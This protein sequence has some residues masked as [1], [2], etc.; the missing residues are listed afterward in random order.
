MDP[1]RTRI[2][3]LSDLNSAH[4]LKPFSDA[5][6]Q[7]LIDYA[8]Q[9]QLLLTPA[10]QECYLT[11]EGGD[12]T[13]IAVTAPAFLRICARTDLW[14]PGR[15]SF[16]VLDE[17]AGLIAIASCFV[18]DS[19]S[20]PW[21]EVSDHA[22]YRDFVERDLDSDPVKPSTPPDSLWNICPTRLLQEAAEVQAAFKALGDR[23]AEHHPD[24]GEPTCM[25]HVKYRLARGARRS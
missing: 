6:G 19:I 7:R 18:R 21:R 12:I 15:V 13:V 11:K 20:D 16:Q 3:S 5:D 4:L 25:T 22:R 9:H 8:R 17:P 2:E 24:Y 10:I 23:I 1:S 14:R